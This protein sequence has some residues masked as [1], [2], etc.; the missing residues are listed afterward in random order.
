MQTKQKI[1]EIKNNTKKQYQNI[2]KQ[3]LIQK[4]KTNK[5]KQRISTKSK[6]HTKIKQKFKSKNK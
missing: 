1:K 4:N 5:K 3:I 2:I 6:T